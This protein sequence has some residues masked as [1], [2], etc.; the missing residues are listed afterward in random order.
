MV[1][2]S[3]QTML[4]WNN[5]CWFFQ[6]YLCVRLYLKSYVF[7]RTLWQFNLQ[8]AVK[9]WTRVPIV[10]I[11]SIFLKHSDWFVKTWSLFLKKISQKCHYCAITITVTDVIVCRNVGGIA[12]FCFPY[13]PFAPRLPKWRVFDCQHNALR[14]NVALNNTLWQNI[15]HEA[16]KIPESK[17]RNF[18]RT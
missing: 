1:E 11:C 14:L 18:S 4:L 8:T 12:Y 9:I 2:K 5:G 16:I 7:R 10:F 13:L 17:C 15:K 6:K 3:S